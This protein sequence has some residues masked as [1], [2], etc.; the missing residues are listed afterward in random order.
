MARRA[1]YSSW[2][3]LFVSLALLVFTYGVTQTVQRFQHWSFILILVLAALLSA[4]LIAWAIRE[5]SPRERD[6]HLIGHE[7]LA[8]VGGVAGGVIAAVTLSLA[9]NSALDQQESL[10]TQT[11]LMEHQKA[12]L[13]RIESELKL[14]RQT[15]FAPAPST[16][17]P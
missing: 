8:M 6:I 9:L 15:V 3:T 5:W 4:S 11:Q 1:R 2:F 14:F 10:R 12:A 13:E 16:P 7:T 17:T